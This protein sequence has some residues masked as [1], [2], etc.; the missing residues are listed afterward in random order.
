M[1][2]KTYDELVEI[3]HFPNW[4][5]NSLHP[6]RTLIISVSGSGSGKTNVSFIK[7]NKSSKTIY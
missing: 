3:N 4:S 5:Y 1:M 7:L 2:T 6:Y